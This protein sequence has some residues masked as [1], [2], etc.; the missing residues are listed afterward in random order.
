[1]FWVFILRRIA[2]VQ[3]ASIRQAVNPSFRD[4][5]SDPDSD[6]GGLQAPLSPAAGISADA[7]GHLPF[8]VGSRRR[9][10]LVKAL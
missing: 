5:D 1:V 8:S 9:S 6:R 7:T 4:F 2:D 3:D 10:P